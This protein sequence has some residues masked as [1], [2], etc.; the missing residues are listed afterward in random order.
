[1]LR[2]TGTLAAILIAIVFL[3]FATPVSAATGSDL[4]CTP[5]SSASLTF[6]PP[7]SNSPQAVRNTVARQYGPCVAPTHPDIT[8]G[9]SNASAVFPNG[10]CQSL[11]GSNPITLTITWNTGQ[12]TTLSGN[13]V[14][15]MVGVNLVSTTTGTVTAGVFAGD[16]FVHNV[17]YTGQDV[18]LCNLGL[19]TVSSLY[20]Q[21]TLEIIAP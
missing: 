4:T 16:T 9:T 11:L 2:I 5:P 14:S 1:M 7:L 10:T 18:L 13:N 15:S 21:I 17:V 20:G 12:T 3:P 6:D 8:A 19:G